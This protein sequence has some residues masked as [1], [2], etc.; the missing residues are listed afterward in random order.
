MCSGQ[1][2]TRHI[3]RSVGVTI[4]QGFAGL[5]LRMLLAAGAG[6]HRTGR[7]THDES[8]DV[9]ADADR[10]AGWGHRV[11]KIPC[12][13]QCLCVR[14]RPGGAR[15]GPVGFWPSSASQ[16]LSEILVRR[17]RSVARARRRCRHRGRR[18]CTRCSS[19]LRRKG[20]SSPQGSSFR[21]P[22][23]GVLRSTRRRR[24]R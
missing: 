21:L 5:A 1:A 16:R 4:R 7:T 8:D 12:G 11:C 9:C 24:A 18:R 14:A 15:S 6:R 2:V 13:R 23:G 10:V 19:G 22:H 20:E 17:S 3:S